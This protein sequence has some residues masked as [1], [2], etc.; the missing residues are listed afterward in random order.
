MIG[1]IGQALGCANL[2]PF[3]LFDVEFNVAMFE[4]IPLANTRFSIAEWNRSNL[5]EFGHFHLW[6]LQG[7]G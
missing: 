4:P 7:D 2:Q 5:G 6:L 1:I 3:Y